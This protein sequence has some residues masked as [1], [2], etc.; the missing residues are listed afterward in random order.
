MPAAPSNGDPAASARAAFVSPETRTLDLGL[1]PLELGGSIP[2]TVGYRAWGTLSP[3]GDNCVVVCHALTGSADA[4]RWWTRMFG[5]GRA[6]D[7]DK[8]F[9]LCS[10]I[11]G[12]CYG[13]TGPSSIDPS[14]GAP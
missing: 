13:T 4:D 10:N 6:L 7:P 11:L 12:S 1:V 9:V 14:T 2:V 8:D 3:A 5:P